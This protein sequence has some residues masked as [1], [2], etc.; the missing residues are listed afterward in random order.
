[1]A[2]NLK[3]FY[4]SSLTKAK[5]K[6]R[7]KHQEEGVASDHLINAKSSGE[8]PFVAEKRQSVRKADFF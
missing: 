8:Q 5:T 4:G 1:L 3:A 7:R 6:V 2:A